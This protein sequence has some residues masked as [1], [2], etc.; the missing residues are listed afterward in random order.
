MHRVL[1]GLVAALIATGPLAAQPDRYDTG[2]RLVEFE[3]AWDATPDPAARKRTT[4][5]L[6][7]AMASFFGGRLGD[8]ARLLE[9]ARHALASDQPPEPAR[10]AAASLSIRPAARLFDPAAGPL[11][12]RVVRLFQPPA[13]DDAKY[14]VSLTILVNGAARPNS[15]AKVESVPAEFPLTVD[16]LPEGDHA[17]RWTIRSGD[18]TLAGGECRLSAVY[19]LEER[20]AR[21]GATVEKLPTETLT[22]EQRTLR[23]HV[24]LLQK[25]SRGVTLETD[26]P[27]HRLLVEAE[28]LAELAPGAKYFTGERA[29][30]YW[31][32]LE[33]TK[34]GT[35]VR[36]VAPETP[37]GQKR[38][39][40]VAM[41]GAGG[42]ENM[43]FDAYGHGA[44]VR[45]AAK[46]GWFLVATRTEF[47]GA[48]P[49]GAIVDELARRFPI[50]TSRVFLV[51]HS[52]GAG[53]AIALAQQ[54][55]ERWAG[56][57]ALGGGGRP[58][59]PEAFRT[60]PL[61][62]G[63]GTEDFAINGARALARS[64][65]AAGGTV[66]EKEYAD[67]EHIVIVQVALPDVFAWYDR[68][69]PR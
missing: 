61:F 21:L 38:P 23:S 20:L 48:P 34:G 22:T 40:V 19:R 14:V 37:A 47:F 11:A 45:E 2:R 58:G 9:S 33:T 1:S 29:G 65:K 24:A 63:V 55:P 30:E 64:A 69:P 43:F 10:V 39:L 8:A 57:A 13:G 44:V 26:Y 28:K 60:T 52:M 68:L 6:K 5:Y 62:V 49:V 59:K 18:Q 4:P 51:G 46:R 35:A 16:G 56:V 17:L 53:Q 12:V 15:E 3:R 54:S 32:T 42:S 41:H 36:M 31:L 27:A 67:I 7:Q 66:V 50:D 25:L